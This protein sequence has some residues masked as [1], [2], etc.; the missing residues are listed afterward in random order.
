MAGINSMEDIFEAWRDYLQEVDD[1]LKDD[2]SVPSSPEPVQ[3][4]HVE[5]AVEKI[6][7]SVMEMKRKQ[8]HKRDIGNL[9]QVRGCS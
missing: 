6:K 8:A 5:A 4:R 7:N 2:L 1:V 3:I 9:E